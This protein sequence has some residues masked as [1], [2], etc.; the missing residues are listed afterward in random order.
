MADN[1]YMFVRLTTFRI[2]T[3]Q[4]VSLHALTDYL[5]KL[6]T[7]HVPKPVHM[8]NSWIKSITNVCILVLLPILYSQILII[9][10]V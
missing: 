8:I 4:H 1:V 6:L 9:D 5:L 7:T 3:H 10:L 2:Q